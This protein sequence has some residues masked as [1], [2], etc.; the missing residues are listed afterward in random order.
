[1]DDFCRK[2][3]SGEPL[4]FPPLN[5]TQGCLK[6]ASRLQLNVGEQGSVK[7]IED[8]YQH[9]Q[10]IHT[11]QF[12]YFRVRKTYSKNFVFQMNFLIVRLVGSSEDR[13]ELLDRFQCP[14]EFLQK[15]SHRKPPPTQAKPQIEPISPT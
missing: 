11:G 8:I 13:F 14:V 6:E 1:M 7:M 10:L 3:K 12:F 4:N 9:A 5:P 15:S 2:I